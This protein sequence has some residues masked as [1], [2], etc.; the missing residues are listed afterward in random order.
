MGRPGVGEPGYVYAL[1]SVFPLPEKSE[2][3]RGG[4]VEEL[5]VRFPPR[6]SQKRASRHAL[7]TRPD[8]ERDEGPG[9]QEA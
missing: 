9:A 7:K 2:I 1:L 4:G 3:D 8:D 5:R 6:V